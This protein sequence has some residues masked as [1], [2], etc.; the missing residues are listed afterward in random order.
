MNRVKA[1]A[2]GIAFLVFTIG[3]VSTTYAEDSLRVVATTGMIADV[4]SNVGG[5]AVNVESLIAPGV[6]P[7]LYKPTR[8]D[9]AAI[10]QAEMVFYNGLYLEGKMID[11]LQRSAKSGKPVYAVAELLDK[12]Y[13]IATD[14]FSGQYDPH[15]WMDPLSWLMIVDVVEQKLSEKIPE[16]SNEFKVNGDK[17]RS[18]IKKLHQHNQSIISSVPAEKRILVTAHDA[19]NYFGKRYGLEVVGIQGLSTESE[20][21]VKDIERII[22]LLVSKKVSAVFI[23]S[24]V[25][26]KNIRALLEGARHQGHTVKIG[27]SLYSD[28]MGAQGTY[29]GTYIGMIDH[30]ATIIARGL[31]GVAPKGGFQGKLEHRS[32]H[33]DKE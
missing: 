7:H 24:T 5:S 14:T 1:V 2:Q 17:Y 12:E 30:N 19:F 27:G 26:D 9:V 20:A 16:K 25:S 11:A 13:L 15:L 32:E 22:D 28:A 4:V 3:A 8:K 6:D 23:E 10:L 21:G 29:V 31:G 33:G 18:V